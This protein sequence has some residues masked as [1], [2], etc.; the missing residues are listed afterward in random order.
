[1]V[2]SIYLFLIFVIRSFGVPVSHI[3]ASIRTYFVVILFIMAILNFMIY[4]YLNN[5]LLNASA[6]RREIQKR[7]ERYEKIKTKPLIGNFAQSPDALQLIFGRTAVL[8][9]LVHLPALYGLLLG[10]L[11]VTIPFLVLI[12]ISIFQFYYLIRQLED[13]LNSPVCVIPCV[14][15]LNGTFQL[16]DGYLF[17]PLSPAHT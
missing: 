1:M 6:I 5:T 14:I 9:T 11:G 12:A 13:I 15:H 16:P 10:V 8:S 17:D 7:Q 4:S 3:P 2:P